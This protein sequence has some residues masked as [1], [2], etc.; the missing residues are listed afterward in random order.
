MRQLLLA[1]RHAVLATISVRRAGWPFASLAPYATTRDGEPLLLLSELAEHTRNLR[2]DSRASL[3]VQDSRASEDPQAGARV[4][5]LGTAHQL[6][7]DASAEAR[8][9]Y[10][11]RQP[12]SIAYLQL[13]DFHL[14]VLRVTEARIV[15][16]FGDMG[17]LD[18]ERLRAALCCQ[19]Y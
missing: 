13:A 14:W 1:E 10:T 5:L 11:Q 9:L 8:Q 16:G 15:N 2:A 12:Q 17:W 19:P 4:T 7:D 6:A 18:G 3:L